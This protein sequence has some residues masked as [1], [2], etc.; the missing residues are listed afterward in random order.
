MIIR[1]VGN[2]L[3]RKEFI[4][5]LESLYLI[6]LFKDESLRCPAVTLKRTVGIFDDKI[7]SFVRSRDHFVP[8]SVILLDHTF[9]T[10]KGFSHDVI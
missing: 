3:R 2:V 10:F 5:Y 6:A 8:A 9:C 1:E 4:L 7:F